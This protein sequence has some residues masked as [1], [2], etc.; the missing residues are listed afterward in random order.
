MRRFPSEMRLLISS[1]ILFVL[2]DKSCWLMSS[3][4]KISISLNELE[5]FNLSL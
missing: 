2:A 3:H 4:L 5:L 1:A